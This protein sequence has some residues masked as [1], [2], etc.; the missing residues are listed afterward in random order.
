MNQE[1]GGVKRIRRSIQKI[2]DSF[3][4]QEYELT[5]LLGTELRDGQIIEIDQRELD[6][7]I[8]PGKIGRAHV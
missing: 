5:P 8:A 6:A 4:T 3:K 2:H 7:D 1:D